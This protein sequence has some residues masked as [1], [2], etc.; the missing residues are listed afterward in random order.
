MLKIPKK[1]VEKIIKQGLSDAP[2]EACGILAGKDGQVEKIYLMTNRDNS[3]EHY[4]M[5]PEEQFRVVKDIR[6][7][8]FEMLAI[9]HTHPETPAR[10]SQEDISLA[11]TPDVIYV[12]A[13]LVD[14]KKP[15]IMGF[16]IEDGL[17]NKIE[18]EITE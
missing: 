14:A 15:D 7:N 9:Y 1:I 6:N 4:T 16:L 2:L 5:V 3:N 8:G 10:P 12:I 13:S 18:L 17:V 11:L